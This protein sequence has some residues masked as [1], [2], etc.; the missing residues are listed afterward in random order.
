MGQTVKRIVLAYSGDL[1]TSVAIPWL[2]ERFGAEVIAVTLDLG[3]GRELTDIRERALSAGAR[4]AHVLDVR[5]EFAREYVLPVLHADAVHEDGRPLVA[6]LAR[7]LIARKLVDVARMEGAYAIGHGCKAADRALF[8]RSIHALDPRVEVIAPACLW[9]MSGA[10]VAEYARRHGIAAPDARPTLDNADANL[11]GRSIACVAA[12]AANADALDEVYTL[13]RAPHAAPDEPACLDI[14]FDA[15]VPIRANGIDMPLVELIESLE[16]IAGAHGVGRIT[17]TER[18]ADGTF[19]CEISEAPAAV[20]LHAAH[21]ALQR[22]VAPPDQ[23]P[24]LDE[25]GCAYADLVS[26]G[27]WFSP[28][29]KV[30]DDVFTAMQPR[31][32]GVV[33]LKLLKGDCMVETVAPRDREANA[34]QPVVR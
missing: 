12:D 33:R 2:V 1:D 26:G 24:M 19:S 14:E 23:Q 27:L 10:D 3:Q 18:R 11:W 13:T 4:R 7:P 31:V 34:G 6:A 8:D 32:N 22:R 5:D 17:R 9:A 21:R 16:T 20:V 30:V 28:T 29:R 15:G 25:F